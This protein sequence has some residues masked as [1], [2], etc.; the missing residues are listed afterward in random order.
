MHEFTALFYIFTALTNFIS[1]SRL[2]NLKKYHWQL[3]NSQLQ[4]TQITIHHWVEPS[5]AKVWDNKHGWHSIIQ[6]MFR[7]TNKMLFMPNIFKCTRYFSNLHSS[8]HNMVRHS[9]Y[10]LSHSTSHYKHDNISISCPW[11]YGNG[12][13]VVIFFFFFFS[14][15]L[16]TYDRDERF[17]YRMHV[18][19]T[20]NKTLSTSISL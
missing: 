17:P 19:W 2:L 6:L 20:V 15:N 8:S 3:R 14:E 13:Q 18:Y 12:W 4:Y 9:E 10:S 1:N 5:W 7:Y 16:C 11:A